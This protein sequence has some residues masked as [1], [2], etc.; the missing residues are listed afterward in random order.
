MLISQSPVHCSRWPPNR[1]CFYFQQAATIDSRNGFQPRTEAHRKHMLFQLVIPNASE[2]VGGKSF[3]W[4]NCGGPPLL[5]SS[6]LSAGS[7]AEQSGI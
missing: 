5:S 1:T 4:A 7:A 2:Y 3:D 6:S